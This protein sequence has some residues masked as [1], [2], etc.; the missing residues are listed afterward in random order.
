M[1]GS[2]S[3]LA[4]AA[5]VALLPAFVGA[6]AAQQREF[7][8]AQRANVEALR[9]YAWKSRTELKLKGESRHVRLEQVRYDLDGRLQKTQ[10]GGGLQSQETRGGRGRSGG[11]IRQRVNAKK[12]EEFSDLMN[13]LATLAASYTH[14]P[15]DRLQA[16]GA[17]ATISKGQGIET[18]SIRI[19]G[20]DVLAAGDAMVVWIDPVSSM[21]RRVE[22]TTA[23]DAKPVGVVADYRSLDNGLTYQAR[24]ALRYPEK[25]VELTV[26]N[27][28]YQYVGT[29]Q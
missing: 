23:L 21:M 16:F 17:R 13:D 19:E 12:Q 6:P 22:I 29:P 10:I 8:Q 2:M 7:V 14:L 4:G 11:P 1:A 27:F 24:A 3:H 18:G 26:E 25:E 20:R 5:V 28:E 15:P 9:E